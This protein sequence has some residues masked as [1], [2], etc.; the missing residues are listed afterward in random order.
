MTTDELLEKLPKLIGNNGTRGAYFIDKNEDQIGWL[1]LHNEG[2]SAP[3]KAFYDDT[4]G[5]VVCMNPLD[6][7][8]P[9]NNAVAWGETPNEALQGLYDWCKE[10]GF[11]KEKTNE[12]K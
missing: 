4:F 1:T 6:E 3:W 2:G 9:Y 7:N 5:G 10:N 8:P 12:S 11:I